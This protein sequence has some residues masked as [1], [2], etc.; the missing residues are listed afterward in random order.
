MPENTT[1]TLPK[2]FIYLSEADSSIIQ[3]VKYFTNDNFMGKRVA[4]CEKPVI[5]LTKEA[6]KGLI[7]IQTKLKTLGFSLKVFDGYRPQMAVEDFWEWS[8]L[9]ETNKTKEKYYPDIDK[10]ELF[11]KGYISRFSNHSRGSTVD[12]TIVNLENGKDL[13][14][15]TI[16][17]FLGK[18][19]H[20]DYPGLSI[21]AREGRKLLRN[22]MMYGGFQNYPK[23]WW[24]YEFIEEPFNKT[25]EHHF[26]FP[27][28]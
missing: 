9:E 20:T 23:E 27:V 14:M 18:E 26:N 5:I 3:D 25:P 22:S 8:Q 1:Q 24:H 7:K 12:I 21:K 2:G 19:S 11:D 28:R 17:D 15:G 4:G 16:F 6:V 10:S 13:D